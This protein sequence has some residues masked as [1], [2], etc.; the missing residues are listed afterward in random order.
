MAAPVVGAIDQEAA[1]AS[2]ALLDRLFGLL[3][4]LGAFVILEAALIGVDYLVPN[5]GDAP[6]AVVR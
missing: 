5:E 4:G 2:G 1:N 6:G 3:G